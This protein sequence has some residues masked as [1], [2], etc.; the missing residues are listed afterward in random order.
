MEL[1]GNKLARSDYQPVTTKEGYV[2]YSG[3]DEFFDDIH[4]S[5]VWIK[6]ERPGEP[7]TPPTAP[8]ETKESPRTEQRD[9]NLR[10]E[11]AAMEIVK[12]ANDGKTGKV[13]TYT[14]AAG[15][16]VPAVPVK[17]YGLNASLSVDTMETLAAGK[18]GLNVT[19]DNGAAGVLVPAGFPMAREPDRLG[20]SL[21]W[22][23][24]PLNTNLMKSAVKGD[25]AKT[26]V[27]KLGGG[28]LPTTATVTLKT[29]L[30]GKVNVYHWDEDTRKATLIASP[31]ADSGKVT[32]AAKRLGNFILTTG[33][34]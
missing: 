17:M 27:Y 6:E 34:I 3:K 28:T 21:G 11:N 33:T 16:S 13:Q 10:A 18:T 20:Y 2:T 25:N 31:T 1:E 19:L 23:K 15:A 9:D 24:D 4:E 26:E 8:A 22:Q 29:K 7:V 30:T 32:F 12:A 5:Y 14:T